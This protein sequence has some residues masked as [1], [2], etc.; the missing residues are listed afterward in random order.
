MYDMVTLDV[1]CGNVWCG[2]GYVIS[3]KVYVLRVKG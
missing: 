2:K 3:G 1:W